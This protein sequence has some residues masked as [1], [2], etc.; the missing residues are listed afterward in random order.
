MKLIIWLWN[1]WTKYEKTRHN[2]WFLFLNY[3]QNK[4]KFPSFKEE[5]KFFWEISEWEINWEKHILVK[6]LTFMNVSW[7]CVLAIKNFYKINNE[8][9]IIIYDDK[10]II[11]NNIRYREEWSSGWHN[12]IKDIISALWTKEFSR[13]KIWVAYENTRIKDTADFVLSKF[14]NEQLSILETVFEKVELMLN[15]WINK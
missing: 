4:I 1:P 15:K 10:D 11:F 13:I 12:W 14:T 2:A 5:K 9:I 3:F 6:P 8:D 7:N